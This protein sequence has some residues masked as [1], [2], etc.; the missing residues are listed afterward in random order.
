MPHEWTKEEMVNFD[1]EKAGGSDL[2]SLDVKEGSSEEVG[3]RTN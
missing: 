2:F 3:R 1:T